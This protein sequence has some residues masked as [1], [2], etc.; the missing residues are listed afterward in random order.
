MSLFRDMFFALPRLLN[1]DSFLQRSRTV[2]NAFIRNRSL[3]F[4][5]MIAMILLM[6]NL[7]LPDGLRRLLGVVLPEGKRCTAQAFSKRRQLI[8][9]QALK[10]LFKRTVDIAS[11]SSNLL[12]LNGMRVFAID[13][14]HIGLPTHPELVEHFGIQ[15]SSGN[16]PMALISSLYDPLNRLAFDLRIGPYNGNEREMAVDHINAAFDHLLKEG[17]PVLFM[18]DRGYPSSKLIRVITE[19][20]NCFYLMR[21]SETFTAHMQITGDDCWIN[22][23][24]SS[25]KDHVFHIRCVRVLL[26]D[27]SIE[28]LVTNLP[29]DYTAE[30]L[31]AFYYDRWKIEIS[32][33]FVK[34]RI[35]LGNLS[36]IT[37]TSV[38]QEIYAAYVLLNLAGAYYCQFRHLEMYASQSNH[39]KRDKRLC[40]TRILNCIKDA[41]L[42]LLSPKSRRS[43][44]KAIR[45]VLDSIHPSRVKNIFAYYLPRGVNKPRVRVHPGV[46]FSQSQR[47]CP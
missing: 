41:F 8:K 46:K 18:F 10:E 37:Y 36:G 1:S 28:H 7:P 17:E 23:R 6:S 35:G 39:R 16:L 24:F 45:R 32:Y 13:G 40:M 4:H 38:M 11:R 34:N 30:Y 25:M 21:C 47:F 9:Y 27:G 43:M 3:S 22:H 12:R 5:S 29:N 31:K 20:S 15:E 26:P 42:E 33:S 14:S 19:K 44:G 2:P